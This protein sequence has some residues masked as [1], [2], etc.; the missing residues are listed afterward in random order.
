MAAKDASEKGKWWRFSLLLI[1]FASLWFFLF[2]WINRQ[3]N[4]TAD[5][6]FYGTTASSYWVFFISAV[7]YG[8]TTWGIYY[9]IK[10]A[11]YEKSFQSF[12]KGTQFIMTLAGIPLLI[13]LPFLYLGVT[14]ALVISEEK[15]QFESFWSLKETE[16]SWEEDVQGVVIDY[17]ITTTTKIPH[18]RHFNGRYIL[19]FKDG[20][21]IDMWEGVLEGNLSSMKKIDRTIKKKQIPFTVRKVPTEE[22]MDEF[23]NQKDSE[24]IHDFYSR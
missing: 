3:I 5:V 14:H 22:E 1:L 2:Y 6:L 19:H 18:K 12:K 15:I 8:I 13:S 21:K 16:Y 23:F 10:Q 20:K 24:I 11:R 4:S 7:L 9:T 17:S